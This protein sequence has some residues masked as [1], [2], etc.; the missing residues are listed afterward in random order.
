MKLVRTHTGKKGFQK[1]LDFDGGGTISQGAKF[2]GITVET[3]ISSHWVCDDDDFV[4]IESVKPS[5]LTKDITVVAII[6][7]RAQ[8]VYLMAA[9]AVLYEG[10]YYFA[11]NQYETIMC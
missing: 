2:F 5:D 10:Y 9:K 1:Y 7:A 4:E 6:G 3:A 8:R 11:E